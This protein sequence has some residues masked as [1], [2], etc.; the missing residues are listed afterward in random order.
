MPSSVPVRAVPPPVVAVGGVSGASVL[1]FKNAGGG[2]NT[3]RLAGST[4]VMIGA[5]AALIPTLMLFMSLVSAYIVRRGL[6]QDWVP[7]DLPGVLWAST[8]I[9]LASSACLERSR[10]GVCAGR[11]PGLWIWLTVAGG[12]VFLVAQVVAWRQ[13]LA[14]GIGLGATPYGSFLYVL[15]GT[16]AVHLV[17]ALAGVMAAAVWPARG[18]LD[19]SRSAAVRAAA[20]IWHFLGVL[21]LGLFL[22]LV[23]WR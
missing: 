4:V 8:A 23:L 17:L 9:L 2:E 13:M 6:G 14:A 15:S 5:W 10:R 20:V 12:T 21:W 11:A 19:V 3:T 16:H 7:V 18:W 22:L 1:K